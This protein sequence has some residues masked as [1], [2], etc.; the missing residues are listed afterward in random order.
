MTG[1]FNSG[2]FN[3]KGEWIPGES[4]FDEAGEYSL[5]QDLIKELLEIAQKYQGRIKDKT[6]AEAA[7]KVVKKFEH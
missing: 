5:Q 4:P 3:W 1:K 2:H 6:I 7:M